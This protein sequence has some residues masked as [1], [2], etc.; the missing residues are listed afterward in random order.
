[1]R[2][3]YIIRNNII[4]YVESDLYIRRYIHYSRLILR[5]WKKNNSKIEVHKKRNDWRLDK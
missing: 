4:R 3:I 2:N 1:M 5:C